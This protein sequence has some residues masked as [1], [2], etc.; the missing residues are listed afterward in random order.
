MKI[1]IIELV[2]TISI[3]SQSSSG[4][5]PGDRTTATA[6]RAALSELRLE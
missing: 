4:T 5:D 1:G 3:A 2:R 6:E